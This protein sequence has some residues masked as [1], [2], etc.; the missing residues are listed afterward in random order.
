MN[1][2]NP[3]RPAADQLPLMNDDR[4]AILEDRVF[5]AIESE[6]AASVRRSVAQGRVWMAGAAAA[7]VVA[8][9]AIIAPTVLSGL[10]TNEGAAAGTVSA[11]MSVDGGMSG[12]EIA[13]T[14]G[15]VVDSSVGGK[16]MDSAIGE[17]GRSIIASSSA[18]VVVDDVRAAADQIAT[19]ADRR[20]GY[21]ESMSIGSDYTGAPVDLADP[22]V[23]VTNGWIIVRVPADDLADAMGDLEQVGEVTAS[24]IDRFDVTD[25]VVDLQARADAAQASVDR[26]LELMAQAGS[27]SDL[28]AAES[29]LAERQATLESYQQQL[30]SL[31]D[32]VAMSSLSVSFTV[33]HEAADANPAGFWDG[34]VAGWNGLVA[35]LNGI[36]VALGFLIPWIAV[37]AVIGGVVWGVVVLVRRRRAP[38][39]RSE[40]GA[41]AST[42]RSGQTPR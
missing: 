22:G 15:A 12:G 16:A 2:E 8:V 4:I 33:R 19:A 7:A 32:Q 28:I 38:P 26:L 20:G 42:Q 10:S 23:A 25:Q 5:T 17:S 18:T 3:Q 24:S 9:A 35:T 27:V 37:L 41:V 11:D 40:L 13:L 30:E 34:L 31:E 29:A 39:R 36:V 14:D 6:R 1:T 21:V